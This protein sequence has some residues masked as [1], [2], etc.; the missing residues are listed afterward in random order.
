MNTRLMLEGIASDDRLVECNWK[1]H[2]SAHHTRGF[3]YF[4]HI[5]IRLRLD[6]GFTRLDC[7]DQLLKRAITRSLAYAVDRNLDLCRSAVNSSKAVGHRQTQIIV[8]MGAVSHRIAASGL[9][10]D[11]A[12]QLGHLLGQ[13]VAQRIGKINDRRSF[14][15][16]RFNQ[17]NDKISA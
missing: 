10:S 16:N 5:N 9:R 1:M 15:N 14:F 12:E 4:I 11:R 2:R 3:I 8:A 17:L 7:H 6:H 13:R